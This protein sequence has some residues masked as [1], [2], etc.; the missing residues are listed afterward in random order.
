MNSYEENRK[1]LQALRDEYTR[2][3]EAIH[4]DSHHKEEPVEKDFAE[5]A[6]QSENDDVLSAL[7]NDAQLMLIQINAALSCIE[8]GTYGLCHTCGEKIPD[9]RLEAV[10]FAELCIDCAEEKSH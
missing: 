1:K 2:R 10:P 9:E 5:Q 4:I 7:D 3:I 8:N 6:T